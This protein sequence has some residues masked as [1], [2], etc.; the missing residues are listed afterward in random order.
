MFTKEIAPALQEAGVEF[1]D[2]D[3]LDDDA[4]AELTREFEDRIFPVLTPLAV[5]PAHPFPYISNLSLNLA[6]VGAR[7]GDAASSDSRG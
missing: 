5:D 2:W 4:R 1:A 3:D 6:V 7:P